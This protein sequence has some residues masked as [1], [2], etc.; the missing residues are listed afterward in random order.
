MRVRVSSDR[1]VFT[2]LLAAL[3]LA[4]TPP[5][6]TARTLS[7]ST[8]GQPLVPRFN[9]GVFPAQARTT[10]A[11][12]TSGQDLGFASGVPL[13]SGGTRWYCMP[14]ACALFA[15]VVGTGL[16]GGHRIRVRRLRQRARLREPLA[17]R[18]IP[19]PVKRALLVDDE[20]YNIL[21]LDRILG[22]LGYQTDHAVNGHDAWARLREHCY[23]LVF[24]DWELP[25]MNGIEVT[26]LFRQWEPPGARALI[27]ATTAYGTPE[28]QHE[29]L[30]AGM[31][32]FVAKPL[33]P[34]T[35]KATIQNLRIQPWKLACLPAAIGAP[36]PDPSKAATG[37]P[38]GAAEV[39]TVPGSSADTLPLQVATGAR[40]DLAKATTGRTPVVA[41][42]V[43]IEGRAR[44]PGAPGLISGADPEPSQRII[45]LSTFR[46]LSDGQPE[47]LRQLAGQFIAAFDQDV[48]LLAEAVR[49]GSVESTR[50]QAHRILSQTAL[51][52]A[53]RLAA[54]VGAIQEAARRGDIETP[55]RTLPA[56][57][58]EVASLKSGLRSALETN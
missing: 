49:S 38:P 23:D 19:Q 15:L 28:T 11:A 47:K 42:S 55:R 1:R 54:V 56:L 57:E 6:A 52:S 33:N 30:E 22:G 13:Q 9:P 12:R 3:I 53:S 34:E 24:M 8:A 16:Y 17:P 45:D 36:P 18:L 4:V 51:L 46:Y 43:L 26:R 5:A 31:D 35:I 40:S 32:G 29:C 10:I 37:S 7:G 48:A 21:L 39:P 44:P 27:I 2:G 58:A 14:W 41:G 25:G 20:K 50:R